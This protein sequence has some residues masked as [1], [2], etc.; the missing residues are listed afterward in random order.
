VVLSPDGKLGGVGGTSA[1]AP[2]WSALIARLN[3]A[4]GTRVGY[5]NP[6]LYGRLSSVLRDISQGNNGA[7]PAASGWDPCTGLGAPGA[8]TLLDGLQGK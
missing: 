3:E 5:L 1:A 2:L 8:T 4:L 6:L 7:Y